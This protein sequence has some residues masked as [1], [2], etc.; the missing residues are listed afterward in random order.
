[1]YVYHSDPR[2]PNQ[3][4]WEEGG[5]PTV[6]TIKSINSTQMTG[7]F[8]SSFSAGIASVDFTARWCPRLLLCN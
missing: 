3:T 2:F 7:H 4:T 6:L 1:M 8:Q 5:V